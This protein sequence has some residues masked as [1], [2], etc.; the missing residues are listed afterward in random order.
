M[1]SAPNTTYHLYTFYASSCAARI[2]IA[3]NLKDIA[4][5]SHYVDMTTDDHESDEYRSLNPSAAIPTLVV[6]TSQGTD[7]GPSKFS[8]TQS[9]AILEYLEE[10]F[11]DKNP[12]LPKDP[13]E[14]VRVRELMYIL[15]SDIFPPTNARIAMRVRAIR[16]SRDD[17]MAFARKIL[18]EGFT[19]YEKMLEKYSKGKKYSA[20]DEVTLADVCLI[21]QVEQARFYGI[22]FGQWP[23]LSDVIERLEALEAFK[24]AGWKRQ[25]DTPEEHR[26]KDEE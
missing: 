5:E 14:R 1:A 24:K 4:I 16:D 10:T 12:L 15:T 19:A 8:L 9:V 25:G 3:V 2:R 20:G 6:E 17:Q 11:P 21:P 7:T 22:E 18:I 23:L 13:L 26:V